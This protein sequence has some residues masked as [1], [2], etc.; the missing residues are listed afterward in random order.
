[1]RPLAGRS[2]QAVTAAGIAVE[3]KEAP[4]EDSAVEIGA[5][6]ALD[7]ARYAAALRTGSRE[8][9]LEVLANHLV[10][11]RLFGAPRRVGGRLR[12]GMCALHRREGAVRTFGPGEGANSVPL[13][14]RRSAAWRG[15]AARIR[16]E[17]FT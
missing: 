8:K 5:E 9:G 17:P 7:E 15:R 14:G 4:G 16:G 1:M 11:Q 13:A 3:A 2:D 12:G 10:E 6:L